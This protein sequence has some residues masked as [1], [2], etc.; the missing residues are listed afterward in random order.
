MVFFKMPPGTTAT[1]STPNLKHEKIHGFWLVLIKTT[2]AL[3]RSEL[4][5]H[6]CWAGFNPFMGYWGPKSR[7]LGL[8]IFT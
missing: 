8:N 5:I 3:Y 7:Y 1:K 2:S 6:K 4:K